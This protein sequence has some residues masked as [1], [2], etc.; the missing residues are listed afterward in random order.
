MIFALRGSVVISNGLGNMGLWMF[1]S[2]LWNNLSQPE[3][4][5]ALY[6]AEYLLREAL[7]WD[8]NNVQA[9]R[10]LGF[11][12]EAQGQKDEALMTWQF[13][14]GIAEEFMQRGHQA[15]RAMRLEEA[16]TW[17]DRAIAVEPQIG[18]AWYYTGV[19]YERMGRWEKALDAYEQAV[20]IGAFADVTRSSPYYRMGLIY[21]QRLKPKRARAALTAFELAINLGEFKSDLEAADAHYRYGAILRQLGE[22]PVKYIQEFRR[23]IALNPRHVFAHIALGV[24]YYAEYEDAVKA[25][26]EIRAALQINPQSK[27]AYLHLGDIYRQERRCNEAQEMY[28][29]ASEIDSGFELAEERQQMACGEGKG[30]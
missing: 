20:K 11:V 3:G 7:R 19:V 26:E 2:Y 21:H 16:E 29:R 18:D 28:R 10:A 5:V 17:Y 25:E 15:R 27:W 6:K 1:A 30:Q 9:R 24:A 14:D 13:V 12:A 8:S 22:D 23:A 4:I